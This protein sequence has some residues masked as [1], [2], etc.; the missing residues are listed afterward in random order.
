MNSA[1][2]RSP[3]T[4]AVDSSRKIIG[5]DAS[6]DIR[7]VRAFLSVSRRHA[8]IWSMNGE[9]WISD[10]GSR[11]GTH[12]NG[13]SIGRHAVRLCYG[14]RIS[15]GELELVLECSDDPD[16]SS[17]SD[18]GSEDAGTDDSRMPDGSNC[19]L[20]D[21]EI[22]ILLWIS[23]GAVR[24]CDI[25]KKVH[26]SPHTVRTHVGSILRKLNLHSRAELAAFDWK[27]RGGDVNEH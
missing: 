11:C 4:H 9:C 18:P 2:G 21:C 15:L 20:T 23:R 14:D 25:A 26:R 27:T 24:D 19:T 10:L 16:A 17:P 13:V 5:R 7:V 22:E 12:V 6:A 1:L 3:R 8:E